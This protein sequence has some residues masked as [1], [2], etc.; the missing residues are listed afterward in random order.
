MSTYLDTKGR[1]FYT[2]L[3]SS[4][5]YD[6]I[7]QY[8]DKFTDVGL[9]KFLVD[10]DGTIHTIDGEYTL[11]DAEWKNS[12]QLDS[13]VTTMHW[14][15]TD[16]S[17]KFY[18]TQDYADFKAKWK[19]VKDKWPHLRFSLTLRNDGARK[20]FESL[21]KNW[22]GTDGTPA[23][24]R[25]ADQI[26]TLL[27][28]WD[29][30]DGIDYD[31]ERGAYL[32]TDQFINFAQM[33]YNVAKDA[34]KQVNWCLPP[35]EAP[36]SPSWEAWCDYSRLHPY[37][38]SAVIM[39]YAFSWAGSAP[40]PVGP[41]WWMDVVY[42][43]ASTVIP[44]H[45]LYLGVG[46]FGFRWDITKLQ[47]KYNDGTYDTY[48]GA[49][50]G[51]WAW[52]EWMN[53]KLTHTDIYR[54][55]SQTQ[56]Y[57]PFAG[58]YD[59]ENHC[60]YLYL[61]I[62]DY[63]FSNDYE[64]RDANGKYV[65][66]GPINIAYDKGKP[67][68]TSYSKAQAP[69]S[70]LF[71][72][73]VVRRWVPSITDTNYK[74]TPPGAWYNNGARGIATKTPKEPTE[75]DAGEVQ[76]VYTKTFDVPTSGTYK[77]VFKIIVPFFG[78]DNLKVTVDGTD[79]SLSSIPWWWQG[80]T[81]EQFYEIS[82][83][84]LSAGAHTLV[85]KG[86][87]ESAS[88]FSILEILVVRQFNNK[89]ITGELKYTAHLRKLKGWVYADIPKD[90]SGAPTDDSRPVPYDVY[91]DQN[92]FVIPAETLRRVPD[93]FAIW[94]DDWRYLSDPDEEGNSINLMIEYWDIY[95]DDT[96]I[97]KYEDIPKAIPTIYPDPLTTTANG[98]VLGLI[99]GLNAPSPHIRVQISFDRSGGN[100]NY[101]V[102]VGAQ[103][104]RNY[105]MVQF[106]RPSTVRI[107]QCVNGSFT[108]KASGTI[109]LP[110]TD[111]FTCEVRVRNGIIE[112]YRGN[113][114]ISGTSAITKVVTY[115]AGITGGSVGFRTN[116]T[117][118]SSY[119]FSLNDA[120]RYMPR[121]KYSIEVR[122][123]SGRVLLANSNI[124]QLTRTG[125]TYEDVFGSF[126]VNSNIEEDQTREV[127]ISKDWDYFRTNEVTLP[128]GD[129]EITYQAQ[130]IGIWFHAAYICD[131]DGA[132]IAYFNDNSTIIEFMNQAKWRWGLAGTGFWVLGNEDE[133]LFTYLP[134][135]V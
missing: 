29:W 53:G 36:G 15:S 52:Y 87:P 25:L 95:L 77:L 43:Y 108:Q 110:A 76:G 98:I 40:G 12:G 70:I 14:E 47:T 1:K 48:R 111:K 46:G 6:R 30:V 117:S 64:N 69:E 38:D 119:L 82:T 92:K 9:F 19:A 21:G 133:S 118:I 89:F 41:Q 62:Y 20:I 44:K 83:M 114:E 3:W 72:Q 60:P 88:A 8:G 71:P 109:D 99:K 17:E 63:L 129:Y 122:D 61:H 113:S 11:D 126:V 96:L 65:G 120:W 5:A 2:W 105:W 124:G 112:V 104:Y 56:P 106:I 134:S 80:R 66:T 107:Y 23:W 24:T 86:P 54:G 123:S 115:N 4:S 100:G 42:N 101:G 78:K 121:E 13:K 57:I 116:N 75:E 135:H 58:F 102:I 132:S 67:Y 103:D 79:H 125:V 84:S 74:D 130:D 59:M 49:S 131:A 50:G 27:Q 85:I 55:N 91:P 94:P 37:F 22:T 34:G 39:S 93:Y 128:P 90:S 127:T 28:E 68:A 7:M 33:L 35:M 31:F 73:G 10:P 97:E 81:S 18:G 45:K 32:S 16:G 26:R 51:M